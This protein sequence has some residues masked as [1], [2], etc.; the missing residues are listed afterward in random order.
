MA[1]YTLKSL[2]VFELLLSSGLD[3]NQI[4]DNNHTIKDKIVERS[5]VETNAEYNTAINF[6]LNKYNAKTCKEILRDNEEALRH[7]RL[8]KTLIGI[9]AVI[10]GWF[11]YKYYK[12]L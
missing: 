1:S 11:L 3:I 4:Y 6:L 8:K 10:V 12:G 2:K 5:K 9:S 7:N